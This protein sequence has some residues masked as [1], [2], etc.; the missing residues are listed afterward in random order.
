VVLLIDDD[1][2]SKAF[3]IQVDRVARTFA[4][5]VAALQERRWDLLLLD[6]DF[7]DFDAEGKEYTGHSVATWLEENPQYLPLRV[8]A[9]SRNPVGGDNIRAAIDSAR[10]R[11]E[12][13]GIDTEG[14]IG[15]TL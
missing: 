10:R 6:H 1:P 15:V 5:G 14:P 8:V 12:R 11:A 2:Q 3:G 13:E 4:E 9:V 7:G